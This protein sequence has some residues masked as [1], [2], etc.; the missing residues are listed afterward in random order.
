MSAG[1]LPVQGGEFEYGR[2]FKRFICWKTGVALRGSG[3]VTDEG[4]AGW[5]RG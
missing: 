3:S 4:K 1:R 2:L 5:Q